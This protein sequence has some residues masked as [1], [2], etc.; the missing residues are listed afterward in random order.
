M[1]DPMISVITPVYNMEAFIGPAIQSVLDQTFPDFELLLIDDCS[2]DGSLAVMESYAARDHRIKILRTPVNSWAHAAGNVGLDHA[3]GKY[4]AILDADDL[5]A[6]ERF[7]QQIAVLDRRQEIDVCGG[8][9]QLFGESNKTLN[10]FRLDDLAIRMGML[11]DSTM[12]H[13]TAMIRR[14]IIEDHHIRYNT[15]I[16]Y[17]HD[18]HFFTQ[19][20]FDGKA[21]FTGIPEIVYYYR[22]HSA[23]TS[24]TKR[25]EQIGYSD[26]VRK[27]VLARFGVTNTDLTATHLHFCH[28]EPYKIID[29]VNSVTAYYEAL[30]GA[31]DRLGIFPVG[32]FRAYLADK[33][34]GDMRRCGLDG[35]RF[36]RSFKHRKDANWTSTMLLKFALKSLRPSPKN[37]LDQA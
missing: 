29:P 34:C 12:G 3:T 6:P 26:V 15:E 10:T 4:I 22:W 20:A 32:P 11:F 24:V 7:A 27:S 28:K 35:L 31:N 13:G 25:R 2:T 23:Q 1:T 19:L 21:T 30:T 5:L 8:W 14:R 33:I 17:A 9:M 16:F 37:R 36:Y 18:Y